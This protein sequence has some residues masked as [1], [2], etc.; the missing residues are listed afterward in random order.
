M[1]C[2]FEKVKLQTAATPTLSEDGLAQ[3]IAE[4]G[5]SVS[6]EFENRTAKE[7]L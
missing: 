7:Q 2:R 5:I 3:Q 4:Q 6:P 1:V